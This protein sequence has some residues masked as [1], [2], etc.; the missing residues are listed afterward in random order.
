MA[1]DYYSILGVPKTASQREIRSAY[2]RLAREKHPDRF[3][4]PDERD[5][6]EQ[7]FQLINESFNHLRDEKLRREYDKSLERK[8]MTP[9]QEAELYYKNGELQEQ[10][11]DYDAALKYY[12]EAM[13]LVPDNVTY[14]LA[15]A[16]LVAMDRS[17]QR[18]AAELFEQA[19]ATEPKAREAYIGLGGLFSHSGMITRAVRVYEKGLRELPQDS[20]LRTL[21]SQAAAQARRGKK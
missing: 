5:K 8:A 14:I 6:A 9:K 19:M 4:D 11:K 18:Q 21:H 3:R 10:S 13:R 15:A 1:E 2:L 20:E 17:K 12:Y 7:R 16:R